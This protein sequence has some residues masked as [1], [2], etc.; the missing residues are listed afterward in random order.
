MTS[1]YDNYLKRRGKITKSL[2]QKIVD[3]ARKG[4]GEDEEGFWQPTA[5]K[6]GNGWAI[7]RF[8]PPGGG[9]EDPY[10]HYYEYSFKSDI[11]AYYIERSRRSLGRDEA[12]PC[13]EFV[14]KFWDAKDETTARKYARRQV[15]ISNILVIDDPENPENNGKV[16]KFRYGAQIQQ[17]IDEAFQPKIPS[18]PQID[19]F[20]LL[21]GANF[22]LIIGRKD[23]FRSYENS[24]F[25]APSPVSKDTKEIGRILDESHPLQDIVHPDKFKSYDKLLARLIKVVGAD[26]YEATM[27][28]ET[29]KPAKKERKAEKSSAKTESPFKEDDEDQDETQDESDLDSILDELDLD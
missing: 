21:E 1:S 25:D 26:L 10:V 16:F 13:Y 7:I 14:Q 27:T 4:F 24:K 5:D 8:I 11:G 3:K 20:D 6:S 19:A 28:G 18:D 12:D 2:N 23:K 22:K 15:F 17:K 29:K 9:E